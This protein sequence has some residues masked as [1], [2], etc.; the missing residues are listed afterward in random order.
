MD[1]LK[2][3]ALVARLA[4]RHGLS[5]DAVE[6]VLR[7]LRSG[8]GSMAQFSHAEFGGMSQ[9][10]SAM[11]M[12][13]D[14]FND[15]LRAKL[16]AVATDLVAYLRDNPEVAHNLKVGRAV[17]AHP[18]RPDRRT[19]CATRSIPTRGDWSSRM[20]GSVRSTTPA[21]TLSR[22]SPRR[23]VRDATLAFRSQNGLVRLSEL[24]KAD[25]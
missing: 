25:A 15:A 21:I 22:G 3:T 7:A 11:T 18:H 13:G 2:E 10:S 19:I 24:K 23:K 17:S 12:V 6:T 1:D 14:M 20:P 8:G 16:N 9:W 5:R 4:E